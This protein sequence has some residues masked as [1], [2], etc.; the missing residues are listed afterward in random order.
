MTASQPSREVIE[1][2]IES[3]ISFLDAI[4]GDPDME[5]GDEDSCPAYDDDLSPRPHLYPFGPGDPEDA[6]PDY[7]DFF[8]E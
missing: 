2:L 4:D 6:E 1:R 7:R 3:L 8:V 5:D